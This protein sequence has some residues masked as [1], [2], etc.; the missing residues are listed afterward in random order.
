MKNSTPAKTRKAGRPKGSKTTSKKTIP[1]SAVHCPSCHST[2]YEVIKKL[3][4]QIY[5]GVSP[6]G[7]KY[8]SIIRRSVQCKHCSQRFLTIEKPFDPAKW[9]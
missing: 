3:N 2:S 7:E 6:A 1:Q 9:V 8:T 5:S 4:E